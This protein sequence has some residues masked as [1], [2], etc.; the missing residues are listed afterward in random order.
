MTA[1]TFVFTKNFSELSHKVAVEKYN[2][3][4]QKLKL[5]RDTIWYYTKPG[6]RIQEH[7]KAIVD[8]LWGTGRSS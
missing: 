1:N 4:Y 5:G 3:F 8:G 7:P 6:V 2:L